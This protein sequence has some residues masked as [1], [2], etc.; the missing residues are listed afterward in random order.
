MSKPETELKLKQLPIK[1]SPVHVATAP[2]ES[3][4]EMRVGIL[5]EEG[6]D[7]FI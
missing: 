7:S 5:E 2:N 6:M 1:E 4:T 3:V